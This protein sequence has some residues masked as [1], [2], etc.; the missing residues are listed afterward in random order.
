MDVVFTTGTGGA[1]T[2]PPTVTMTAPVDGATVTGAAVPVSAD[3]D[4]DVGVTSV[5]FLLDGAALDT[6]DTSSPYSTTWDS[7]TVADGSHTLSAQASDAAGNTTTANPVTVTVSN[8][9]GADM[10]PPTVTMT[11]PV[12]G[13]MVTGAAVPVSANATTM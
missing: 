6:P 5:Q 4:D 8:G 9:G 10:T 7:T 13:A 2:T 3:A 11:A 12:D 1:D